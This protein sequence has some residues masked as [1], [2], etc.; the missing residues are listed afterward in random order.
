MNVPGTRNGFD[1]DRVNAALIGTIFQGKLRHFTVIDSTNVRALADAKCGADAGQ[2]YV[3]DQQTAGRGRGGHA[4]HSEPGSGLYLTALVRPSLSSNEV[5]K[6]SIMAAL[7]VVRAVEVVT[8][9]KILDLRWPNDLV[10]RQRTGPSRKAGGI[11]T[12]VGSSPSG[13]VRYA[14]IGI[15]MNLN[16]TVFP[17]DLHDSA[18]SLRL[19]LGHTVSREELAIAL[20]NELHVELRRANPGDPGVGEVPSLF[21]RFELASSW[22][23]GKRVHVSEAEG[24][25]GV[26]SGLNEAGL[27]RVTC[28]DGGERVVRHGGVREL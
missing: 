16:Q 24:Y 14:A 15:G 7:A 28:D 23:H 5:L 25:T 26:T 8:A 21:D 19:E 9:S 18:T 17:E 22:V 2:V 3:A 10:V 11:L 6:L 27:L 20:L 1:P 12:E 4:W 13:E